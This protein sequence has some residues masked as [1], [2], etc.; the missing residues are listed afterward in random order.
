MQIHAQPNMFHLFTKGLDAKTYHFVRYVFGGGGGGGHRNRS[1]YLHHQNHFIFRWNVL[2]PAVIQSHIVRPDMIS[3]HMVQNASVILQK[4]CIFSVLQ[5]C[6]FPPG[7][8]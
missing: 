6:V 5:P 2:G 4:E 3:V 7:F 1:R 8:P